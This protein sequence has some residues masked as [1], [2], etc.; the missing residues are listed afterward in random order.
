[1]LEIT[2]EQLESLIGGLVWPLTRI[3]AFFMVA[4]VLSSKGIPTQIKLLLGLSLTIAI[5][6]MLPAPPKIPLFSGYGFMVL[7]Q[8]MLI[9]LSLGFAMR[10]A[11]ATVEMAGEYVAMKMGLGFATFFSAESDTNTQVLSR[12]FHLITMLLFLAMDGHILMIETLVHTF[13]LLP[14]GEVDLQ[15]EPIQQILVWGSVIFSAGLL[16]S[17][18]IVAPLLIVSISL[19]ILNRTAP[20]MSV[21]SVGFPMTLIMGLILLM[22]MIPAM[23]TF[24][25]SVFEQGLDLMERVAD[26]YRINPA[27]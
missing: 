21:F 6:S 11:F 13:F 3:L 7:F 19:G 12:L 22:V 10:V 9:G 1:M 24:M 18:P 4:P 5:F 2:G 27:S 20:Q 14:A 17:L 23:S 15:R 26:G 8:Q 25:T 16:L